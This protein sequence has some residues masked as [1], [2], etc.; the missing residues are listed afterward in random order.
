V[1]VTD[2]GTAE[3]LLAVAER[4]RRRIHALVI[5]VAPHGQDN[6]A[7][8]DDGTTGLL[9]DLT[10]SI[11]RELYPEQAATSIDDLLLAADAA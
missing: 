7:H 6:A 8:A 3:N 10:V 4:F 2:V 9:T 11:G 1:L 5:D